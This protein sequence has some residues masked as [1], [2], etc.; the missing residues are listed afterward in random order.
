MSLVLAQRSA[1]RLVLATAAVGAGLIHLAFVPSHV[2][3]YLPLGVAFLAAGVFQVLWGL[4]VAVRD[5]PQW[6]LV[7]GALSFVFVAV[8]L[9]SRTVGL[10]L[11]PEAFEAEAF[12]A[13][14]LL[15]CALEVPVGIAA[16]VLGRRPG[17]LQT[18]LGA[19]W[20]VGFAASLVL[21]GS[22]SA[23]ALATSNEHEHGHS[24]EHGDSHSHN[25]GTACPSAPVRTGVV[26]ER[27]VDTGVT[28]YFRCL[29][30]HQHDGTDHHA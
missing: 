23:T 14:D 11:G 6:L 2:R 28:A 12:G 21:V 7:G 8:Y 1:A 30:E 17:A 25:Q 29:L 26:D 13:S 19:R 18:R 27:G 3:E 9:L 15:C 24:D 4:L 5:S 10:P 16:M 22:A 20:A